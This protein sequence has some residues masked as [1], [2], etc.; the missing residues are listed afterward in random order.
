MGGHS[1]RLTTVLQTTLEG[2]LFT[3]DPLTNLIAIT[4]TPPPP[5]PASASQSPLPGDYRIIPI[6]KLQSFQLLA[7]APES[8]SSSS[9]TTTAVSSSAAQDLGQPG[10]STGLKKID[11]NA[12]R[13]RERMAVDKELKKERS[14][15]QGVG[16]EA[17]DIFDA[18]SRTYVSP[19][20]RLRKLIAQI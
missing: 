17:Q 8:S 2:T 19:Y 9:A 1:I 5:T 18:L 4:T 20:F 15:G 10:A 16:K 13:S 14:R 11:W 3:A 7:L 12:L 6:S